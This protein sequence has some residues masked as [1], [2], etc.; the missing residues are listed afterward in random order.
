MDMMTDMFLA[1][2]SIMHWPI[3]I[4]GLILIFKE[5]EMT[6]YQIGTHNG[7]TDY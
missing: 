4:T 5:V 3:A 6:I 7:P 1:Y 2:N